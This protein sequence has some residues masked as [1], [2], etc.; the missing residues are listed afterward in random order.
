MWVMNQFFGDK[1]DE[2]RED[3]DHDDIVEKL[4][5]L[6][7][8]EWKDK[9]PENLMDSKYFREIPEFLQSRKKTLT[10]ESVNKINV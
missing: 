3:D 8:D 10:C 6:Y 4:S 9:S 2:E 5:A 7:G 1:A